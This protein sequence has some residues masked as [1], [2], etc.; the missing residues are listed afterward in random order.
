MS[1]R[2]YISTSI[3]REERLDKPVRISLLASAMLEAVKRLEDEEPDQKRGPRD[4]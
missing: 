2:V 1:K 3:L 4:S